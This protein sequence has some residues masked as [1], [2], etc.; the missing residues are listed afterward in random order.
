MHTV[1][2][3]DMRQWEPYARLYFCGYSSYALILIRANA[4]P[5]MNQQAVKDPFTLKD[6][7]GREQYGRT[8]LFYGQ[9]FAS[10]RAIV[11]ENGNLRYNIKEGATHYQ[12]DINT[13]EHPDRYVDCGRKQQEV[14]QPETCIFFPRMYHSDYQQAY[15]SWISPMKGKRVSYHDPVNGT[16]RSITIPA[17]S[18]NLRFFY[19]IN[20]TLCIGAIFFGILLDAKTIY[21]DMAIRNMAIGL[22]D[23][24]V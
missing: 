15:L 12:Q 17:F 23:S 22:Q 21:K 5:P 18:D 10:P 1:S 3:T 6:Y 16:E 19:D 8:P 9:T 14:Y 20:L 13:D 7:L 24:Q 2:K 11:R 4:N